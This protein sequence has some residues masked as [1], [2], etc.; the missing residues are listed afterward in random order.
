MAHGDGAMDKEA[1]MGKEAPISTEI[2]T[3]MERGREGG[4]ICETA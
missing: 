3:D 1:K 4:G 2:E